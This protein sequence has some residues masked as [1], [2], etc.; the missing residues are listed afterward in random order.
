[1]SKNDSKS[2]P[3]SSKNDK[4]KATNPCKPITFT[5]TFNGRYSDNSKKSVGV[6]FT[7]TPVDISCSLPSKTAYDAAVINLYRKWNGFQTTLA[8]KY[9]AAGKA[10]PT[11]IRRNTTL[12]GSS[13]NC[14]SGPCLMCY[15]SKDS[16]Q[17]TWGTCIQC[18]C[19]TSC[20][21]IV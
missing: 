6:N 7:T 19:N 21:E 12:T 17:A 5:L 20:W 4:A 2:N 3:K 16:C 14:S 1:M 9:K 10:A 13:S 15:G 8:K 18:P 11:L